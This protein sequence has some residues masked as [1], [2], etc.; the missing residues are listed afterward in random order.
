MASISDRLIE[1]LNGR[2]EELNRHLAT[3]NRQGGQVAPT[4]RGG[5]GNQGGGRGGPQAADEDGRL[6]KMVGQIDGVI[7]G[8]GRLRNALSSLVGMGLTIANTVKG[9]ADTVAGMV[10]A[11]S[12]SIESATKKLISYN[13]SLLSLS[14][15]FSKYGTGIREVEAH[16]KAL[17]DATGLTYEQTMELMSTYE[18][19]FNFASLQ[20]GEKLMMNLRNAVGSNV[21][22]M[23]SMQQ[24]IQGIA[25]KFPDLEM[26]MVRLNATDKQ[27]LAVQSQL[28]VASGQMSLSQ[29]KG[30]QNYVNQNAQPNKADN[31]RKTE[32][33]DQ[34]MSIKKV[35]QTFEKVLLDMSG[36]VGAYWKKIGDAITANQGT[37]DDWTHTIGNSVLALE[38][39]QEALSLWRGTGGVILSAVS[40]LV[41][42][43]YNYIAN[44]AVASEAGGATAGATATAEGATEAVAT[45]T[46]ATVGA[47]EALAPVV[48]AA[49]APT[50][51]AGGAG[52]GGTVLAPILG[53]MGGR[54]LGGLG[55]GDK[56]SLNMGAGE[57]LDVG[58][59]INV[60]GKVNQQ[61]LGGVLG[62][63]ATGM[64]TGGPLGAAVGALAGAGMAAYATY[65]YITQ[66]HEDIKKNADNSYKMLA[67]GA[68]RLGVMA[69]KA[70]QAATDFHARAAI[71][72][73][74]GDKTTADDLDQQ[75]DIAQ[76]T[77][78][79][80][81]RKK[82]NTSQLATADREFD[83]WKTENG[84]QGGNENDNQ[85]EFQKS[86]EKDLGK[87][88]K[89]GGS[90][91]P[92]ESKRLSAAR[93]YQKL[94]AEQKENPSPPPHA[95]LGP[96]ESNF[97]S[98]TPITTPTTTPVLTAQ[99]ASTAGIIVR[100]RDSTASPSVKSKPY[101]V[102]GTLIYAKASATVIT[103]PTL[104]SYEG[105]QTKSPFTLSMPATAGMIVYMAA[106]W[107]T[108][109]GLLGPWSPII[110]Y[111]SAQA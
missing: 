35:S 66:T 8:F 21:E 81:Q 22:A 77:Q 24:Q 19:G 44:A 34:L 69:D 76:K 84:K 18:S 11:Q 88:Q 2:L 37:I 1:Q 83:N 13:Q 41:N 17:R 16:M 53:A 72:R 52:L 64:A 110:S 23:K 47:T 79:I 59:G 6:T 30:L 89:D 38:A 9:A 105:T 3:M 61:D 28:L 43:A 32:I 26:S 68:S 85:Q 40:N 111:V 46:E 54:L 106:R 55:G 50:V 104:L 51:A 67:D 90:L 109:K 97:L 33:D 60:G 62:G 25:E 96:A 71:A 20:N 48:E 27:R 107:T 86:V 78:N 42:G 45:G 63:A 49:A 82:L 99:S 56:R 93:S 29:A 15:Q 74:N 94:K 65:K 36:T 80:D 7:G 92:E 73:Q 95:T 57:G 5:P 4:N 87:K 108:K 10:D 14:G 103:D 31:G 100:Y 91:T 70:G 39:F 98:V 102:I 75:G 58:M 101:G 12:L